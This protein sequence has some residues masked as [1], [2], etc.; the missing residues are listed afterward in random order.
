MPIDYMLPEFLS[1]K[2]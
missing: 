2:A 1:L